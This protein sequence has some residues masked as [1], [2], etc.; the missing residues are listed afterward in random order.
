MDGRTN[1]T[2][3]LMPG[4]AALIA[5]DETDDGNGLHAVSTTADKVVLDNGSAAILATASGEYETV[6]SNGETV[7]TTVEVPEAIAL[8]VWDIVVEDWNEGEKVVNTEEKFG[9]VTTEVY[10]TTKKTELSFPQSELVAWKDLPATAEQLATLA[11]DEPSMAQ[12]SGI[13]TYTTTFE[14]PENWTEANGAFLTI[15]STNGGETQVF[16]NGQKADGLDLRTL[17]IDI[18]DLLVEGENTIEVRVA[19]SLHN[20][21]LQ[22]GYSGITFYYED[23]GTVHDY[24]MIGEICVVPYVVAEIG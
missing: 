4:E 15:G 16:V 6:L 9:H 10:Y 18:S 14:L 23:D 11:G 12:V 22:R 5:I 3:T 17:C 19:S 2:L 13:A 8:P 7:T 21:M 1:V 24:G 20:R